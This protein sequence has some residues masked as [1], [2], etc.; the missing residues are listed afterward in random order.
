METQVTEAAPFAGDSSQFGPAKWRPLL[1]IAIIII[2]IVALYGIQLVVAVVALA[3]FFASHVGFATNPA[4]LAKLHAQDPALLNE[5]F[6]AS[7]L[8]VTVGIAEIAMAGVGFLLARPFFGAG[9]KQLGLGKAP[10]VSLIGI[11]LIVG[12]ALWAASAVI[13]DAQARLFGDHPQMV[14]K[15]FALHRDAASIAFDFLS[16]CVIAP[17]C[18]EFF[19]R[20]IIFAGL[21][22]RMPVMVAAIASGALFALAHLDQW[23]FV[24]LA[25]IGVGLAYLY[26]YTKSLWPNVIAHFTVNTTSLFL[27][28]AFPQLAK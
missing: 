5:L 1:L 27:I 12:L 2:G 18:E 16:A 4:L 17:F 15:L 28:H 23:A 26:Y 7:T 3:I 20:G 9:A 11:G 19:F 22:Q 13:G 25:V 6:P 10:T 21:A 14:E 24:P 8:A